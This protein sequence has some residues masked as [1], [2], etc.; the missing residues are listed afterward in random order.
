[1]ITVHGLPINLGTLFS[2]RSSYSYI[3]PS[4]SNVN[5]LFGLMIMT[6]LINMKKLCL[7]IMIYCLAIQLHTCRLLELKR[8]A[9]GKTIH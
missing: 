2:E 5:T 3:R 6:Q 8:N 1:M 7:V 4:F 9:C